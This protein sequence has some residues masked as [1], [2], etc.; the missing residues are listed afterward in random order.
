MS[1]DQTWLGTFGQQFG[2]PVDGM[3]ELLA[4]FA[5][6]AVLAE[7]AIHGAD[8]AVVDAFIE[9]AGVDLGRRLVGEA[10]RVQQIQHRPAVAGRSTP[11]PAS[12]SRRGESPAARPAGCAGAAR[13]RV[14]PQAR[15]RPRRSC[16]WPV[17]VQRPPRSRL[18]V[19]G[20][21][22]D[23]QQRR[24]FFLDIDDGFGARQAQRQTGI[25]ALK[26]WP[27]SAASGLGSAAFGPRLPGT[28]APKAP[29]SRCL[30]HSV[31]ADE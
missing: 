17:R 28:S 13:W 18:V 3:A 15:H 27:T 22:R 21:Q 30:R 31:R 14:K 9:Q 11:V 10:R 4:A 19:A 24:N 26:P 12:P 2:L 1:Q 5:D 20:R 8:R 16:R 29:A 6:F 23:A 7:D 25:I